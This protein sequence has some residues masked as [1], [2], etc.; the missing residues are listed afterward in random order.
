[1]EKIEIS[2]KTAEGLLFRAY[3]YRTNERDYYSSKVKLSTEGHK[4]QTRHIAGNLYR[5]DCL[6]RWLV[7]GED[8][9]LIHATKENACCAIALAQDLKGFADI[10]DV[11]QVFGF[12]PDS[13]KSVL[14]ELGIKNLDDM[15]TQIDKKIGE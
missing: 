14:E 11:R 7:D 9:E 2:P 4:M 3:E 15:G 5:Q 1:M 10:D 6:K 8:R 13:F 12:E